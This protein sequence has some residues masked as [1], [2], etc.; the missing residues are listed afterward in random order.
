M[1]ARAPHQRI[2]RGFKLLIS[3]IGKYRLVQSLFFSAKINRSH[4]PHLSGISGPTL[5]ISQNS[6]FMYILRRI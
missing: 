6:A 3:G 5:A 4:I 2:R 1:I